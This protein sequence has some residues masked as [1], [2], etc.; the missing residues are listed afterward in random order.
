MIL[1][2][3]AGDR[4]VRSRLSEAEVLGSDWQVL[5]PSLG[6]GAGNPYG[7]AAFYRGVRLTAE[8][9]GS[10]VLNVYSG[11]GPQ[12]SRVAGSRVARFLASRPNAQQ[13]SFGFRET[14]AESIAT[15][16]NAYVWLMIDPSSGQVVEWWALHP[17]QVTV[18]KV[19][20][21]LVYNVVVK[22]GYVDPTGRG[23]TAKYELSAREMLHVRGFGDG[24]TIVAPSPVEL[25]ADALMAA[26]ERQKHESRF[27]QSG[28]AQALAA[29]FPGDV[30]RDQANQY[31]EHWE[32]TYGG[33]SNAGRLRIL[34][35][36]ADLKPIGLSLRD[37]QF[38]ESLM[39]TVDEAARMTGVPAS[40][41]GGDQAVPLEQE[42]GRWLRFGLGPLCCRIEA[43]LNE[44]PSFGFSRPRAYAAFDTD[45]FVRGDVKTEADIV[46]AHVQSGILLVDEARAVLGLDPLP[47]GLGQIPQIVPVGGSPVGVP[48]LPT[49][50]Q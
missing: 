3:R 12:R 20:G 42:L 5:G 24:G 25:H 18:A 40:L 22:P 46:H 2:G 41:L 48:A 17:D 9:I 31:R 49:P 30:K 11:E 33:A 35:G 38:V 4:E 10:L 43:A 44:H 36:G 19:R 1:T 16:G 14:I 39:L 45:G 37:A 27:Y 23:G 32:A 26:R 34:G 29:I 8:A 50:T 15:R 6:T 28:T 13:S 47:N 7:V 21:E